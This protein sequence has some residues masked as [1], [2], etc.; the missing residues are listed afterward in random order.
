METTNVMMK[1]FLTVLI[2]FLLIVGVDAQ[3]RNVVVNTNGAIVQPT[4]FW[5]ADATN[6]RSGL[7][8]GSA[9]TNP[10]SAFQSASV[11]L[12]NLSLS[13]GGLLTNLSA[14]GLVGAVSVINGGTGAT[15]AGVARTNLG[16]TAV[17]NSVFTA[18]DAAT[19]RT[20][21]GLSGADSVS[22]LSITSL[23][24]LTSIGG[25]YFSNG[26]I[27]NG[28]SESIG[29]TNKTVGLGGINGLVFYG[30]NASTL[31]SRT[32][33]N[34]NI[35][36]AVL[37]NTNNANFIASLF[38]SGTNPV[39]VNSNSVV[40][41]PT[42]F[43]E[44]AP[45]STTI[46]QFTNVV[47]TETNNATNS[48]DL[49]VY[50]LSTS[51]SGITNTVA[52]PTNTSTLNGDIASVIHRGTTSSITAIK[53][54]N[55]STNLIT[56]SNYDATLRFVYEN[57]SWGLFNNNSFV[58]PVSF[59]GTNASVNS[60]TSRTNLG[61]GWPAL[62]E[63]N[64]SRRILKYTTNGYVVGPT[65]GPLIFTNGW[66]GTGTNGIAFLTNVGIAHI[67]T[68]PNV[69]DAGTQLNSYNVR[70]YAVSAG[71]P[72]HYATLSAS[73]GLYINADAPAEGHDAV[74]ATRTNLGLGWP[75]LV[76]TNTSESILKYTT[77]GVA[78]YTNT[79]TL[80]FNALDFTNA[81]LTRSNLGL[82]GT[83]SYSAIGG[84][85]GNTA[86]GTNSV[87]VGG[88]VN[89]ASGA[90]SAVLGGDSNIATAAVS[91]ALG[92]NA[93]ATNAN[94][95]VWSS[96]SAGFASTNTNSFNI[97]ANGG[98]SVSLG[99]AGIIF[100]NNNDVLATRTNLGLGWSALTNTSV[101]G[102][103]AALYGSN[104]NPVLVNS[105]GNVVSPTNFWSVAPIQT[106]V[107]TFAPATNSTN[108]ATNARALYV[109]SLT[110]NI[111]S[112]TNTV[113][114]PTNGGTFAGDTATFIHRGGSN[115][116]TVVAELGATNNLITLTSYDDAVKFI[117]EDG[118]WTFYHN[119]SFVEPI[120]FTG[121]N[122][123]VNVATTRTNLGLGWSA[124][125]NTNSTD[126]QSAAFVTN[127]APT[128]AA[129]VNTV[130]FNTAIH[131]LEV[132]VVTNGVTNS[133]RVPLFK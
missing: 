93:S 10:S 129:N 26:I 4:N 118:S 41:S 16:A 94:S 99:G 40:V 53:A 1:S 43:W 22:F 57:G 119:I 77:N 104:T 87:V 60:E 92:Q 64:I 115:S 67:Q 112:T 58:T 100:R 44:N 110:T 36:L 55:A 24:T 123:A 27:I 6:A 3:T 8:L 73:N 80:K 32:R 30:A 101:A 25:G 97:G 113:L 84:G 7:G 74:G 103:S 79:N 91:F 76:N 11:L 59:A 51:V 39:L 23:G 69:D 96:S 116:A 29:G 20:N 71:N 63:T 65:N 19:A 15:N 48:R 72:L 66:I 33:T 31:A 62:V 81:I 46:Q 128:N 126:F 131:W 13:N 133:F 42:N 61:L 21:L 70:F 124:L 95:F 98:M 85:F 90:N 108:T 122:S 130:N 88:Y 114:L 49:Y 2:S 83:G 12:T 86:S 120:H 47:A 54:V 37:T 28:S 121:T 107:Q 18:V 14:S 78:V 5:S 45:V 68:G 89:A 56:I 34:L 125:T 106:V 117:Y 132:N 38:G 52:L 35:P 82:V 109:Y 75:A 50:S 17:G 105:N 111:V 9:A 127:T 102:F